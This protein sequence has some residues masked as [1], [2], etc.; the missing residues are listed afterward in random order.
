MGGSFFF[1]DEDET[2]GM[3]DMEGFQPVV[4]EDMADYQAAASQHVIEIAKGEPGYFFQVFQLFFRVWVQD[5]YPFVE[6]GW[7]RPPGDIVDY[8][9]DDFFRPVDEVL[10]CE[11]FVEIIQKE[12]AFFFRA[13]ETIFITRSLSCGV[14]K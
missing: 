1:R 6:M 7:V 2:R 13:T 3:I 10:L 9:A 8:A 5:M 4:A 14:R 12:D 11:V